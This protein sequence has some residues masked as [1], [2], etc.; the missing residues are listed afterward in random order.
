[1][2]TAVKLDE[3]ARKDREKL[4][5]ETFGSAYNKAVVVR[6]VKY[7]AALPI[8][9]MVLLAFVSQ[10]L[11]GVTIVCLPWIIKLAVDGY[12]L[13]GNLDGLKWVVLLFFLNFGLNR[14]GQFFM[15]VSLIR[16][17]Q[18]ILYSLRRD[19]FAHMQRLSLS[20]YNKTEVGR[21]MSRVLGDVGQLQEL[22]TMGVAMTGDLITLVGI[23]IALAL[24]DVKLA[25][26][27]LCFLPALFIIAYF[28]QPRA[29]KSF[30]RARQAIST[31]NGELNENITGVRV[32]QSMNR[33]QRNLQIFD[34]KNRENFNATVAA[35]KISTSLVPIVDILRAL[36]IG[37][38]ILLGAR[39]V[40]AGEIEVGALLAFMLYIQRFFEPIRSL[41]TQ[42]TQ[43]QRSM[44]SGER[45]FELLDTKT[46]VMD[47]EN[48]KDLPPV[49]GRIELQGVR[50]GYAP[51]QE[52]IKGVD[53]VIE[54]GETVA[55]VGP[56]GAGKT[57]LTSLIA[58]FYDVPR[59]QG[60]ILVDG[61]DIRDVTRHSLSHQMSMVLQEP[62][63]F[64]GT[65]RENILLD[66]SDVPQE[67]MVE[68]AKAVGAHDFIMKLEDGYETFLEERGVN[69]SVGQRQLIS[70][71]RAIVA[72]P[73]VLVL[74]E[75][76]ANID[77]STEL[78]IQKA[79][80]VLLKGRTAIVI[81]HRLSTIRGADKIVVLDKGRV[82]EVGNHNELTSRN[83]LYAHLCRM[84]YASLQGAMEAHARG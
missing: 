48:A 33:E 16:A 32:V 43:L 29:K 50:F 10:V 13:K 59:G 37:A 47:A 54:P 57:T 30:I 73:K 81:A 3:K 80:Q 5:S 74:D 72:D 67:K 55:I 83:G 52:I 22:L 76:T 15:E 39:M 64:S 17:G 20:F 2:A 79:L 65:V 46:E 82:V 9:K 6:F 28:W 77:S 61:Q 78:Q 36:S 21:L 38:V 44:A 12:I 40:A 84:N 41:T 34:G 4:E 35:T 71:A 49:K 63:L 58:R 24:I 69:L 25:L 60:A 14:V 66:H 18:T 68:A 23:T 62:F 31:V 7:V 8:R 27:S 26:L 42:Y 11:Y 75:A 19:M 53:L 70:F 51:G 1:M 45:I 56:T